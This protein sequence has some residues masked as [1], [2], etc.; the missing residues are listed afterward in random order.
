MYSGRKK[1]PFLVMTERWG[2]YYFGNNIHQW[3]SFRRK[4]ESRRILDAG[5][6]IPD[7]IWDLDDEVD[8][9]SCWFN[10]VHISRTIQ[11]KLYG[12]IR[13]TQSILSQ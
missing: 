3:L 10:K 7:L 1:T 9:F 6:V 8:I 11:Q 5:S 4:P 12:S 2:F 13:L